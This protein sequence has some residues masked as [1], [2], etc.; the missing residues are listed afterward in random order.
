MFF[1]EPEAAFMNLRRAL[2]PGGRLCV[3]CWRSARDNPWY[4]LPLRAAASVI[5][6]PD[7]PPPESPGPFAL[8]DGERFRRILDAAGFCDV[9]LEAR[10]LS[11][12]LSTEGIDDAV[13]FAILAGPLARI[14]LEGN[15]DR[16]VVPQVQAAV[17]A[18]LAEHASGST[19]AL[20]AGIWIASA[21]A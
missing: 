5:T 10:D 11:L 21:R 17:R 1:S 4:T 9:A 12:R 18:A 15:V 7:P 13:Q 2:R 6:L 14:M 8:A 20:G 16:G 19:V 3:V